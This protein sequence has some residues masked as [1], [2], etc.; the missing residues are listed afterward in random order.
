MRNR[1]N[2][3]LLSAFFLAICMLP[4]AAFA[5]Q[6][7]P[8]TLYG[9]GMTYTSSATPNI[10]GEAIEATQI[11]QGVFNYNS[12]DVYK[13]GSLNHPNIHINPEAGI[14]TVVKTFPKFELLTTVQAGASI[15]G[16]GTTGYALSPGYLIAGK[17]KGNWYW[18]LFGKF[19]TTNTSGNSVAF[20]AHIFWGK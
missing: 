18:S 14:A 9:V 12:F 20:G 11:T 7:T 8:A 3:A 19:T 2:L 16:N 4:R 6:L 1:I 15:T 10:M 17:V 5:Q 13:F